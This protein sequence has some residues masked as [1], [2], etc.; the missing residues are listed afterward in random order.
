MEF[1]A[2]IKRAYSINKKACSYDIIIVAKGFITITEISNS[3]EFIRF[4]NKDNKI[5]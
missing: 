2:C 1:I 3:L 5:L 4:T